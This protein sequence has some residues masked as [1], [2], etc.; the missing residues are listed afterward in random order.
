MDIANLAS[1]PVFST[2][3]DPT[4]MYQTPSLKQ[5]VTKIRRAV[6][7]KQGLCTIFGDV[8]IGKSSLLRFLFAG[9]DADENYQVAFL[10]TGKLPSDFVFLKK[11]SAEFSIPPAR[12]RMAQ[13]DAIEDVLLKEHEAGKTVVVLVDEAQ[14]LSLD[15]LE[16]CRSLLNFETNREKLVQIVLSGQ[17]D[18]RDR[19]EQGRYRAFRSRIVAFRILSPRPPLSAPMS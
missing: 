18:L 10:T 19:L 11:I 5:A 2:S 9:W 13:M 1:V 6:A 16:A 8:G 15:C 4:C 17:L 7:R 14:L 3:P 12:S